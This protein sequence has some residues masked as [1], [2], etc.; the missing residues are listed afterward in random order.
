[1][2]VAYTSIREFIPGYPDAAKVRAIVTNANRLDSL[3]MELQKRD[4]Y[5]ENLR[6]IIA[7]NIPEETDTV[8]IKPEAYAKIKFTRSMQDSVLRQQIEEDEQYN[9][10]L[11]DVNQGKGYSY[12]SY[13][14][15]TPL[16]GLITNSF[17]PEEDHYGIDIVS[18]PNELVKAVLDGTV[19]LSTWTIE[20]GYV[21]EIQHE[22]NLVSAYKHCSELLKVI[23]NR[24]KAGEAI[25]I[26]G[27]SGEL[28]TGPHLHFEL[29]HNGVAINPEDLINF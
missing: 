15:F 27:N 25:A 23:G 9:L 22:N 29:W 12:Q 19:I 28:T 20:T 18:S 7:G 1:V 5:F 21:L 10:L 11:S 24:V 8:T 16:R 17:K 6:N 26:V 14:F 2:L 4:R 3:E 13:H